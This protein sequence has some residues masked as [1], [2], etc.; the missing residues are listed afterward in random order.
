MGR[1]GV[2]EV[3][4]VRRGRG[5]RKEKAG[6]KMNEEGVMGGWEG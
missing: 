5:G 3:R 2:G 1:E 6:D 4:E